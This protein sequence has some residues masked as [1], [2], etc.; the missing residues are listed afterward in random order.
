MARTKKLT[1]NADSK[2]D[3]KADSNLESTV[4]TQNEVNVLETQT[5]ETNLQIITKSK[6]G[7]KPKNALLNDLT[8]NTNENIILYHSDDINKDCCDEEKQIIL[9][10]KDTNTIDE[11]DAQIK[12]AGKKVLRF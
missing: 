5:N 3:S 7:R 12:P 6:R 2:A 11:K 8:T 1:T 9:E 10:I 4:E